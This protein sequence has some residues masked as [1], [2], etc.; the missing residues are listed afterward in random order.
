MA[1]DLLTICSEMAFYKSD[2]N[3]KTL[4]IEY[5]ITD[6]R[7]SKQSADGYT[8]KIQIAKGKKIK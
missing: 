3:M 1:E 2:D 8:L 5:I 4:Q 7:Q 6:T